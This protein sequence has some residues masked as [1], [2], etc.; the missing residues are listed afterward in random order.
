MREPPPWWRRRALTIPPNSLRTWLQLIA[1]EAWMGMYVCL[2]LGFGVAIVASS[3]GQIVTVTDLSACY[4]P[5][6]IAL[7][8]EQVEYR[9]GMLNA[10][11][12]ALVGFLLIAG[13][14]WL[15]WVLWTW[16]EPK[17][18]TDDFLRLLDDSF[19]R[20]WRN[21]LTW[22]WARVFWAYGFTAVGAAL[23]LGVVVLIGMLIQP[24]SKSPPT[25]KIDTSQT[26]RPQ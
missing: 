3:P 5:P 23:T 14:V 24:P 6:P 21:P 15:L 11:F 13:A 2:F 18:I 22:P 25:I 10:A 8:C 20:N 1:W 4:G 26:F 12:M 19:G 9:G 7:P 16:V 17:P